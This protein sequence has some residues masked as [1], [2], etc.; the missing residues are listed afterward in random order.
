[1]IHAHSTNQNYH[2]GLESKKKKNKL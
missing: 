2:F 1:M